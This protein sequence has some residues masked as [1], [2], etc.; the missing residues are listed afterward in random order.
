VS[1][2]DAQLDELKLKHG[3]IA[4][5]DYE[6]HQVVFRKPTRD[7]VREYRRQRES[8]SEKHLAM[9]SL[10]QFTLVAFDGETDVNK[11][12]TLYTSVFLEEFPFF[13]NV[14]RVMG[15]LSILGGMVESE[16]AAALGKGARVL[17][18]RPKPTQPASPN[19]SGTAPEPPTS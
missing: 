11:A 18:V 16:E 9:E 1:L 17:T 10:A 6:G 15:A 14:P 4:V 7:N 13:V 2:S 3:K 5:I 19:G 8:D 12:R